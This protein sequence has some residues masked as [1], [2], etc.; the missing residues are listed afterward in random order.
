VNRLHSFAVDLARSRSERDAAQTAC[1][2][3]SQLLDASGCQVLLRGDRG[4][5][6]V[7]GAYPPGRPSV[8]AVP[9]G[10]VGSALQAEVALME[11]DEDGGELVAFP[12]IGVGEPVGVIVCDCRQRL[13]I[14]QFAIAEQ[15][16]DL[17]AVS[18]AAHQNAAR[19]ERNASAAEALVELSA[20]LGLQP[21]RQGTAELLCMATARLV[22][23][24]AV[25]V[26]VREPGVLLAA[27]TWGYDD[28]GERALARAELSPDGPVIADAVRGRRLVEATL[29]DLPD[30]PLAPARARRQSRLVL[31]GVGERAGNRALVT[32][33]RPPLA[34]PLSEHDHRLLAGIQ[35]QALLAFENR[36]LS[37]RLERASNAVTAR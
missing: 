12:M 23:C 13:D 18:F 22:S 4:V 2:R 19:A 24:D 10:I 34:G 33:V 7:A 9:D 16:A 25:A 5:F 20:A 31:V 27:A 29:H 14:E 28:E 21:T 6:R 15:A 37:E 36:L 1:E 26:W 32:V 30:V 17:C 11:P 8:A 3:L 35:D